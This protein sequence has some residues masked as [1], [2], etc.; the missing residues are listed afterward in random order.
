MTLNFLSSYFYPL[1]PSIT[2]VCHYFWLIIVGA[3][4]QIQGFL[5]AKETLPDVLHPFIYNVN[6]TVLKENYQ[7]LCMFKLFIYTI[8]LYV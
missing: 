3:E 5:Q 7:Y 4:D 6:K 8:H 2:G 1:S